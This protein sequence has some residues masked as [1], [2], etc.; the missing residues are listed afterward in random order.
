MNTFKILQITVIENEI[1]NRT[2]HAP[3]VKFVGQSNT[4]ISSQAMTAITWT[5]S[6]PDLFTNTTE[7]SG[8]SR[9]CKN[10]KQ[11]SQIKRHHWYK[12]VS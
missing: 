1:D 7:L 12:T 4:E 3:F 8:I 2:V 5:Q 6:P 11:A 9:K 10:N